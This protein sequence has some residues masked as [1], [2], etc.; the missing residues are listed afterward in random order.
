[1][2]GWRWWLLHDSTAEVQLCRALPPC[3][4]RSFGRGWFWPLL[5]TWDAPFLSQQYRGLDLGRSGGRCPCQRRHGLG[6]FVSGAGCRALLMSK[7]VL[8]KETHKQ[9]KNTNSS[10]F[11]SFVSNTN[12]QKERGEVVISAPTISNASYSVAW[13]VWMVPVT[14]GPTGL[15]PAVIWWGFFLSKIPSVPLRPI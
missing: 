12:K 4:A 6:A 10:G 1:M 9:S 15:V 5:S 11:Y 3:C 14:I 2:R 7:R 13:G 8:F